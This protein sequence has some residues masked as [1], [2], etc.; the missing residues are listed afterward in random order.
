MPFTMQ[1]GKAVC[2][3]DVPR[4]LLPGW[5]IPQ[6]FNP[7]LRFASAVDKGADWIVS[8][9][10]TDVQLSP[11]PRLDQTDEVG[12]LLLETQRPESIK[13]QETSK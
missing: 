8:S 6:V 7:N 10:A 3:V 9:C 12:T 4:D 2:Y 13:L 5:H 1:M 11:V